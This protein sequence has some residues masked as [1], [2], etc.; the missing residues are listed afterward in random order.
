M[1]YTAANFVASP[2]FMQIATEDAIAQVAKTN[3]Q[4]VELTSKAF[5]LEVPAVVEKV[6]KLVA[7]AAEH[8]A[9]EANAGRLWA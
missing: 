2:A 9:K 5:A 4:S 8:C 7:A 3:G 6:A 1:T